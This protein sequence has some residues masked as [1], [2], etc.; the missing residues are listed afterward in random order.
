MCEVLLKN[1]ETPPIQGIN[2]RAPSFRHAVMVN[3]QF[4]H[5]MNGKIPSESEVRC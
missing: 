1:V 4:Q 5:N 3:D 2:T